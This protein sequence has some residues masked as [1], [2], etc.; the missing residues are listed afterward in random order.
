MQLIK[1][2]I[3]PTLARKPESVCFYVHLSD[4]L[5]SDT[6]LLKNKWTHNRKIKNRQNTGCFSCFIK[7]SFSFKNSLR[8]ILPKR[9]SSMRSQM[10]FVSGSGV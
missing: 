2:I 5:D 4:Y 10:T 6:C 9:V 1:A 3:P 8:C 7:N